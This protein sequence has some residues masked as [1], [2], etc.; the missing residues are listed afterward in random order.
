MKSLLFL[1]LAFFGLTAR[2]HQ[3]YLPASAAPVP[4]PTD[5]SRVV[6]VE[7]VVVI[8]TPKENTRLRKTETSVTLFSKDALQNMGVN[9]LSDLSGFAS[10]FFMPDYGSA[11]TSAI[12][13][14]GVGSRINTPAVG[15][16]VDNVPVMDKSAYD[17]A[18]LDIARVDVLRG[19]QGTLYGRNS[20]G[21]LVRVF[22]A[23][24]FSHM[25]T[26]VSLSGS[27]PNGGRAV[28]AVTYLHPSSRVAM[29]VGG[30]YEG[31]NG[32]RRNAHSGSKADGSEAAGGKVR[33]AWRPSSRLRADLTATYEYSDEKACPYYLTKPSS[34]AS[35]P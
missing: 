15:L 3:D 5:T 1:L 6:D 8:A 13:I 29:S 31:E 21:G 2:A 9:G 24:P 26:D 18:F 35:S 25:G 11:Q 7:E 14:R 33:L 4:T 10:N 12:Y 23:D 30:F 16:Y 32:F 17:F 22:T 27:V 19:P 28:R 20:M 34:P